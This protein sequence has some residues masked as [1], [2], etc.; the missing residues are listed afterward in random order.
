MKKILLLLILL[1][2]LT[3]GCGLFNLNNWVVPDD[4][5]FLVVVE[6]LD[7]PK[8]TCQYMLDN[9]EYEPHLF[10]SL[11]PYQLYTTRKGDC[12]DFATFGIFIANYHNYKTFLIKIYYK[13]CIYKH[14]LAI[15]KENNLY[16]FSDS[17]YYFPVDY[18]SFYDIVEL[19]SQWAFCSYGYIWLKYKVYDYEMN[20]IEEGTNK[21][22]FPNIF[23]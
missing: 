5:E 8:K 13:D 3:S 21:I 6:E 9:F 1:V 20:V 22:Y 14:Y 10:I 18:Y 17:Q 23:N 15:Y 12:D 7:T 4:E 11:S 16:N 19:D 2:M